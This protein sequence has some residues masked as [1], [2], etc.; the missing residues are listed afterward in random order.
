MFAGTQ[1]FQGNLTSQTVVNDNTHIYHAS[2]IV[3]TKFSKTS[4][5]NQFQE[6]NPSIETID[7]DFQT[8]NKID[9][10]TCI[11]LLSVVLV[12]NFMIQ[13]LR[14]KHIFYNKTIKFSSCKYILLRT[15]RI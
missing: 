1:H 12:L 11:K 5:S 9:L 4:N 6:F 7:D 13:G 3:E 15:I 10:E 8:S 14:K 2:K